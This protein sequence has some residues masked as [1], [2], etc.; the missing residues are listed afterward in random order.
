M[1]ASC[2]MYLWEVKNPSESKD[3]YDLCKMVTSVTSK[4]AFRPLKDGSCYFVKT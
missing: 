3:K 1:V 4:D 2:T